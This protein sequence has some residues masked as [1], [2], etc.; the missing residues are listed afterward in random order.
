MLKSRRRGCMGEVSAWLASLAAA[1]VLGGLV[2]RGCGVTDMEAEAIRNNVA[3]WT[4]NSKTGVTTFEWL[5]PTSNT[6]TGSV[7]E[8]K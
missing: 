5:P 7:G 1:G 6:I 4:I 2:G 3:Q 8:I